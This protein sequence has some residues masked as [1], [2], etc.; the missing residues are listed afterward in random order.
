VDQREAGIGAT[1]W[2][3]GARGEWYVVV[4]V[5]LFGLIGLAPL[6]RWGTPGW[7]EPWGV[8]A[9]A[10]GLALGAAGGLLVLA[11]AA[12]LGRHLSALPHPKD[13]AELIEGGAY[14]LARHPIYGGILLGATGWGLLTH[15]GWALAFTALLFG[16][17]E[18]KTRREEAQLAKK[19][20]GYAEYRRRT[21]K[22]IPYLY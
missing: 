21:K 5:I 16:W 17:F 12:G 2:W 18:L 13:D 3:R 10:A 1:P 7:P 8:V 20:A 15:S 11:G 6:A 14:R 9:R 22:F 4:Q 19:F